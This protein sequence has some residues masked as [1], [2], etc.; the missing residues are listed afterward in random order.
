VVGAALP[1]GE[2]AVVH[3]RILESGAR[4]K[5]ILVPDQA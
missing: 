4:G 5:L 1:M 3:R 2:A